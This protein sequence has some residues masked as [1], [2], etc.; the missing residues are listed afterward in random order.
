MII[1]ATELEETSWLLSKEN[2]S[3]ISLREMIRLRHNSKQNV[4]CIAWLVQQYTRLYEKFG[5]VENLNKSIMA[6]KSEWDL[7]T[8]SQ[9]YTMNYTSF[10]VSTGIL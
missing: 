1:D 2:E 5:L 9:S 8:T 6:L 7:H 4:I 10:M 3:T